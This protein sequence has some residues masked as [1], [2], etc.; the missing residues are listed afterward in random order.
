[1][2]TRSNLIITNAAVITMDTRQPEAQAVVVE[3]DRIKYVG[4]SEEA[5]AFQGAGTRVVDAGGNTLMPGIIDSHIHILGGSL[6]LGSAALGEV[7]SL[8]DLARVLKDFTGQHADDTWI[9]GTRIGYD[10]LPEG[11]RLGRKDLDAIIPDHPVILVAYDFH[12]A[13]VNT[14]GL[15]LAGLM[16]GAD[17]GTAGEVVM[18]EDGLAQGEL[19]EMAAYG[20][21]LNMS[22]TYGGLW[23]YDGSATEGMRM[24]RITERTRALVREGLKQAA[25]LG[26]TSLHNMDGDPPQVELYS[27]L[28]EAGELPLRIYFPYSLRPDAPSDALQAAIEMR[29]RHQ[30]G[31]VRCGAVKTLLDGVIEAWTGWMLED[32]A[33]RPGERGEPIWD[34]EAFVDQVLRFDAAGFQIITHA[35][36]DRAIREALNAFE[37]ARRTNGVRDSRH[38]IEHIELLH[39]DDLHR[40]SELDVVASM[41]PLHIPS[42][43]IWPA[44]IW[45]EC[46]PE[47]RWK[48]AFPWRD[49]RRSGARLVF[50]SDWPVASQDPWWGIQTALTRQPLAEGLPDQ[51]QSL[52]EALAAYTRDAAYVEFQE[53]EKGQLRVGC[54]ADMVLLPEDLGSLPAQEIRKVRPILTMCNGEI[55]YRA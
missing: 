39:P 6:Q 20:P 47:E 54:L 31:K 33:N 17:F 44:L 29:E 2:S 55:T 53:N 1:M 21:V 23:G 51:R 22:D 28:E 40:F 43:E 5:Q 18:G 10:I 27:A 15:E 34:Y 35:I 36:G 50:G 38:R 14:R 42:R 9:T 26:I 12:T 41:Q 30:S 48:D 37:Q 32:Y 13:W 8:E 25:Q 19:R 11:E 52:Q 16:R 24:P 45:P 3:G 4:S 7:S 46:V 49:I